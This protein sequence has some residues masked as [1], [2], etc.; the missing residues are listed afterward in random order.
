M[1]KECKRCCRSFGATDFYRRGRRGNRASP[2]G[3]RHR[4]LLG[5]RLGCGSA[6]S[7]NCWSTNTAPVPW[8][9]STLIP[10]V[11]A[12]MEARIARSGMAGRIRGVRVDGGPLPFADASFRCGL[13]QG[14][15]G[16]DTRQGGHFCRNSAGASPGRTLHCQRLAAGRRRAILG[17]DVGI[18]PA[19]RYRLHMATLAESADALRRPDSMD[20]NT[21]PA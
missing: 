2:R 6:P 3:Q 8:S 4:R 5:A 15:A 21:R 11:L 20:R 16:A 10:P 12:G 14:L 17:T 19:R 1:T 9:A 13:L 7:M 18:L